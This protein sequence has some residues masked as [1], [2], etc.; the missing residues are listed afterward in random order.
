MAYIGLDENESVLS[1]HTRK[2]SDLSQSVVDYYVSH[3]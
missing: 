1:E 3:R 2:P